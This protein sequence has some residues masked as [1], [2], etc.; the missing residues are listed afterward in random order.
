MAELAP[1]PRRCPR[2]HHLGPGTM[3]VSFT[4]CGCPGARTDRMGGHVLHSC[5]SCQAEGWRAVRYW[6][7]HTAGHD[8]IRLA[9]SRT[10]ACRRSQQ[11]AGEAERLPGGP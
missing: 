7:W 8:H 4:K 9:G 10:A 3:L 1:T 2:G 5:Q 11:A 6:P